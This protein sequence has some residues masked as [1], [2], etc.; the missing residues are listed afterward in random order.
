MSQSAEEGDINK[1]ALSPDGLG[2]KVRNKKKL[3]ELNLLQYKDAN[4]IEFN[5]NSS[6]DDEEE[7]DEFVV[8][9]SASKFIGSKTH[10][11]M[12]SNGNPD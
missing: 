11:R 5:A 6:S 8:E 1:R 3:T 9:K 7:K 12:V 4:V 10:S 2:E